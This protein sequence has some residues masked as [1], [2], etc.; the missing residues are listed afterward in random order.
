MKSLIKDTYI[1]I[2]AFDWVQTNTICSIFAH[3]TAAKKK[4][5]TSTVSRHGIKPQHGV[6]DELFWFVILA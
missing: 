1:E 3:I 4:L 6:A 2:N 5:R